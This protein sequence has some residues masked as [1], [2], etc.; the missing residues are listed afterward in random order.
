MAVSPVYPGTVLQIGSSG[1]EVARMQTYLN[2]LRAVYPVLPILTV[3]GKYGSGTSKAVSEYQTLRGLQVDGKIGQQTWNAIVEQNNGLTGDS[4]DTYPGISMQNGSTGQD[5]R[6]MQTYLN[7]IART[8]TAINTQTVDGKFGSNC[9]A[10]TQRFQ[11]QFGLTAD[12]VIGK[13]TW[14]R[15]VAVYQ[16]HTP[17]TTPYPGTPVQQGSSGDSVRFVQSYV[18]AAGFP[19]TVDGQF[20]AKTRQAVTAF[21]AVARLTPDGIVGPITW[22]ALVSAFNST[23]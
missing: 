12:G 14:N 4:A 3:D 18:T 8:Y 2:N 10:A 6:H 17:V 5:V 21:Q 13:N 16:T 20:G 1:T 11:R 15:I 7:S 22:G 23:L 19:A 9:T